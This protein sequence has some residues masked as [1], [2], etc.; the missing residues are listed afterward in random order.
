MNAPILSLHYK[1]TFVNPGGDVARY[2]VGL[3]TRDRILSSVRDLLAEIGIEGVTLKAITERARVGAGSFYNLFPSKEDAVLE[4]V[5]G[6]IS[7]VDPDPDR[8]GTDKIEDLVVAY[9][10]FVTGDPGIA[11]I[12]VQM[13]VGGGLTDERI[14]ERTRRSHAQRVARFASALRRKGLS[15]AEALATASLLVASLNGLA[16]TWLLE[17]SFDFEDS[18]RRLMAGALATAV[19]MDGSRAVAP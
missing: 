5:R 15:A 9:A 2:R 13:A 19:E 8:S 4:V 3:E 1:Y 17:S 14:A 7:A 12:Y 18:A 10:R 6:A 11:R 16:V